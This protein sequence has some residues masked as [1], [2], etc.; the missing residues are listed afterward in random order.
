MKNF[1]VAFVATWL[2]VALTPASAQ[3]FS[4]SGKIKKET[5]EPAGNATVVLSARGDSIVLATAL[6]DE[7]GFFVFEKLRAGYYSLLVTVTAYQSYRLDSISIG[8]T[9]IVVPEINLQKETKTLNDVVVSA[10]KPLVTRKNDR[11][12]VNVEAMISAAGSTALDVLEKSPGV[13]VDQN[14]DITLKG[15]QGVTVFIDDKPT[16]LSGEQLASYLRSM[17]ASSIEFVELMSNPPARYDAAGNSGVINIRT[18]KVRQG[19]LNGGLNLALTQGHRTRSN[20]SFNINYRKQ[21]LAVYANLSQGYNNSF[22]DLDLFRQYKNNDGSPRAYFEQNSFFNREG[23]TISYRTGIDFYQN[24]KS[25]WGVAVNGMGRWS[26]QHND[27]TSNLLGAQRQPDSVI[28]ADNHDRQRFT[29][30]G[31]NFNFRH[32]FDKSGQGITADADFITYRN[33]TIQDYRNLITYADGSP[34]YNDRLDGNLPNNI[35]IY[36]LKT[37]YTRP[38]GQG[39]RAEGGLKGSYTETDNVADYLITVGGVT[40]PDYDKSN[41]FIYKESIGAAYLNFSWE[42]KRFSLQAGLRGEH[43]VSDGSQLGNPQKPDSSFNRE[44]TSLFPTIF[45]TYKLDSADRHQFGFRA[46]R[47]IDRPY[48]QDLNPFLSP[49]DKFTYYSGNPFLLPAFTQVLELSHT[50]KNR[51]TTTLSYSRTRNDVAETIEISEGIYYSRPGNIGRRTNKS[52]SIDANLDP[53]K[54]LNL[55]VYS[56][57][58]NLH[59]KSAFYTGELNT[60]GNYWYIGP[61]ARFAVGKGWTAE[62]SGN[63]RTKLTTNQFLLKKIWG[64]NAA[65]QKKI[66]TRMTARLSVNDIFYTRINRGVINNLQLAEASWTNRN[67]SRMATFSFSYSFGKAFSQKKYES[68]GADSEKN[69]VRN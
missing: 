60:S 66:S 14:G 5:N 23:N 62:L 46:G 28:V 33:N 20:N 52:I 39:M 47:R 69:R 67:D 35:E 19:G 49:M 38:L 8:Q 56:E 25:T 6:S 11:T 68:S 27:N 54:W 64:A 26:T 59:S 9:S 57:F 1:F 13:Q 7:Q 43:T 10:R 41:H 15:K 42:M 37:D 65:V 24:K 29:N 55:Y 31:A 51:V 4:I 58:T 32:E 22:T 61:T 21:R 40:G 44:Y 34:G 48:Y 36:S 50:W 30:F 53:F 2:F 45:A 3:L 12:V 16:Y 63:Y 18:K 17:P